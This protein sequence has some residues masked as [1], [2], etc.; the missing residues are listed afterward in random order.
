VKRWAIGLALATMT[1]A[2]SSWA[3]G[4]D[5]GTSCQDICAAGCAGACVEVC[6]NHATRDACELVCNPACYED[7]EP[8]CEKPTCADACAST[9]ASKCA[10]DDASPNCADHCASFCDR[11]CAKGGIGGPATSDPQRQFDPGSHGGTET[12]SAPKHVADDVDPDAPG[13]SAACSFGTSDASGWAA[14]IAG[15]ALVLARRRR[16]A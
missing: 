15:L 16:R 11:R 5:D 7:C 13:T 1:L 9:C 12:P 4:E 6:A 3:G 14:A 2:S 10:E 8:R